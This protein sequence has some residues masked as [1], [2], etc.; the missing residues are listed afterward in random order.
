MKNIIKV[1]YVVMFVLL[2]Q[3]IIFSYTNYN[4]TMADFIGA[5][6]NVNVYDGNRVYKFSKVFKWLRDYTRWE[7]IEGSNNTYSWTGG[8]PDQDAYYSSLNQYGINILMCVQKGTSWISGSDNIP[9]DNGDGSSEVNYRERSEY[10]AQAAARYGQKN[11]HSSSDLES[12]DKKQGLDY[13]RYYED[14]NEPN[15]YWSTPT[16]P[17][18]YYGKYA[19]AVHDGNNCP[20]DGTQPIRGI[21]QGDPNVVHVLGG[22]AGTGVGDGFLDA[23]KNNSTGGRLSFDVLN[24]HV[25]CTG[26]DHGGA[27]DG[28]APEHN[29]YGLKSTVDEIKNWR[30]NNAPGTPI[31]CTE[32]GWDTYA[33]GSAHSYV[34]ARNSYNDAEKAQANYLM[35]SF[36][37]LKGW[38]IEKAFMFME[39]D[40][41]SNS[42]TQ[43]SSCGIIKDDGSTTKKSY[44]YLSCMQNVIG[45]LY[46]N[47]IDKYAI[48]NPA[49]Y[50][51]VFKNNEKTKQV[52]MIWCRDSNSDYDNGTTKNNYIY[53]IPFSTKCTQVKPTNNVTNGIK[54][55]LT[56]TSPGTS[57]AHVTIS[58][59][60]E[61]PLFLL[62]SGTFYTPD[63]P[64]NLTAIAI[65]TN[66]IDLKWDDTSNETGY[67]L[68]RNL[69]NDVN[70]AIKITDI[71]KDITTYNDTSL[72]QSTKY[73]YWVKAYNNFGESGY[74]QEAFATTLSISNFINTNTYNDFSQS[75][76][77][78]NPL[79][80]STQC[81]TVINVPEYTSLKIYSISGELVIELNSSDFLGGNQISWCGKNKDGNKIASGVY[82]YIL[83]CKSYKPKTGK[84]LIIN[85]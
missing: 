78:P 19:N 62:C 33:S 43:Y 47:K 64:Q 41:D 59:I 71:S 40:P 52:Y 58:Q 45:N 83:E 24:F 76:V 26:H 42:T 46:F 6:A 75:A 53:T 22:M 28:Y 1:L 39:K 11:D 3:G 69:E 29:N 54:T 50:S 17:A 80:I 15:Q 14:F 63:T 5:C 77:Y 67:A 74:S 57:Y 31:W 65:S 84:L 32:F 72:D 85:N 23:V 56:I 16:W 27:N 82:F 55:E 36:A 66:E 49:I 13:V 51:Y 44:F 7:W 12:S 61:T 34:Y 48:G 9:Y 81:L 30:D 21:K 60:S 37:L 70:N 79:N 73:Y 20:G 18:N 25:Y 68:F 8:W 2:T 4:D 35:R 38:G 10:M